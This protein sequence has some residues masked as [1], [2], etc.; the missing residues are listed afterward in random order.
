VTDRS[1][2]SQQR[3][4]RVFVSSTF[5]DMFDEREEL[6]KFTFPELRKRC[7]ERQVEFVE[8]DLRWGIPD[9]KKAEGKVLPICLAEIERCRPYFIGLLG[10]RYGWVPEMIDEEL[11][12]IQPW[13]KEHKEKSITEL[14]IVHGVLQNPEIERLAFFYFRD[15]ETSRKVE[16]EISK[17]PDYRPEPEISSTKLKLLKEEILKH[18]KNYPIPVRLNFPDAKTLGKLILEDLW[19]VIDKRFPIE[20]VPTP[21]ERE[22]MEHEAFAVQRRKVYIGREEY[23]NNLDEHTSGDGLPL[24]ILGE[25]G[26]GKSA[27]IANW[28]QRYREK[29]PDD[30]MV[31]H[32]IGSTPDSADYV[33]ILRRI[34]EEIRERYEPRSEK[35]RVNIPPLTKGGEGGFSDEIPND[36]KKAVEVFPLWLAKAAAKGKFILILDALNQLEDRDNAPELGWLP[37]H[38]PPNIRIILSTLTGRSLEALKR[39]QWPTMKVQPIEINERKRFIIDYLEQYRRKLSGVSIDRIASAE[40]SSN[41]LYLRTLLE[42]LRVFGIHEE[43]DKKIN[44]YLKAKTV[45]DLFELVLERLE[46]DYERE[47]ETK[48]LVKNAMS[49]VWASRRGL[50]ETELLELLSMPRAIWSPLYLALEESLVTRSGLLNFFHDFLRKAAEN[51][52]LRAQELKHAAHLRIAD[53]FEKKEVDDRKVDELPWQ[54]KEAEEWERLK[55]CVSEIEIFLKLRT[56]GKDYELIEYWLAIGDRFDMVKVYNAMLNPYQKATT[57]EEDHLSILNEVGSFFLGYEKYDA[58]EPYLRRVLATRETL[59]G[60]EHLNVADSLNNLGMLYYSKGKIS[61]AALYIQ[62]ALAIRKKVCGEEHLDTAASIESLAT[63]MFGMGDTE[64][65]ERLYRKSLVIREKSMGDLHSGIAQ[66]LDNLS[67]VLN[68]R[69]CFDDAERLSRRALNIRE[70]VL[71]F[72]HPVTTQSMNNL[73]NILLGKSDLE[74]AEKLF[75]QALHVRKRMLGPEHPA[76]AASLHN[77]AIMLKNNG[78]DEGAEPLLRM[79][80]SIRKKVFGTEH[81][82][83]RASFISLVLLLAKKGDCEGLKAIYEKF[84]GPDEPNTATNLH[85]FAEEFRKAGNY[86][87]AELLHR[88]ALAIREKALGHKHPDTARSIGHLAN[89]LHDKAVY[90]EAEILYIKAL[91]IYEKVFHEEHPEKAIILNNMA[92]LYRCRGNRDDYNK[93]EY[94][95]RKVLDIRRKI[96]GLKHP[97]SIAALDNLAALLTIKGD[98]DALITTYENVL[99]LEHP[100]MVERLNYFAE[101][102]REDGKYE[103]AEKLYRKALEITERVLG[104]EHPN[105]GACLNNL[106]TLLYKTGDYA[107]A[108]PLYRK[109]LDITENKMGKEHLDTGT[110]LNNLALLLDKKGDYSEA[111]ELYRRALDIR[112]KWLGKEHLLTGRC[113]KNL[114]LLLCKRGDYKGADTLFHRALSIYVKTVGPEH[115]ETIMFEKSYAELRQDV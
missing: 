64:E 15:S 20:K 103:G 101:K 31:L 23:F 44:H 28:T 8:I 13:L 63:L 111:E 97:D 46:S 79:A 11:A 68:V 52:Y 96:F 104:D 35:D 95:L 49:L 16:N 17:N 50:S 34:M 115:P 88:Q 113:I 61:E 32:F 40:Q 72:E 78:N 91:S 33:R 12:G 6:V 42:E 41:P 112:E 108:E 47:E 30:F 60:K 58:A 10:E 39:R 57:P 55:N 26:S 29:H 21:L 106:A 77:L 66:S 105:T 9:E 3:V 27:L 100:Y 4:V 51:H 7:R 38:F 94:L 89:L 85:K 76:T 109:A 75:R 25:S 84:W 2:S 56:M 70:K 1:L 19:K 107:G 82:S 102:L 81:H 93:A 80:L 92:D 5:Q 67:L 83:T 87:E 65:A 71:G 73:A 90:D 86:D 69:G 18:Q 110:A 14:E 99:G 43:L 59:L 98:Y 54:L 22:R 114:A 45:D 24:V 53:Y 36:P 37:E 62:R 48:G 74:E